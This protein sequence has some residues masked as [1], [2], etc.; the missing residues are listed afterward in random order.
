MKSAHTLI[1]KYFERQKKLIKG[2]SLRSLAYDIGVSPG[3]LSK[4]M[5]GKKTLTASIAHRL[6]KHLRVDNLQS[7]E[8]MNSLQNDLLEVNF[9]N[10]HKIRSQIRP[11]VQQMSEIVIMAPQ[12]EW[13]LGQWYR[14]ALLDFVTCSNFKLDIK[15]LAD[16][17]QLN[18]NIMLDTIKQLK[19]YGFLKVDDAGNLV[20]TYKK[21]RFPAEYSKASIRKYH[22]VQMKRAIQHMNVGQQ[23][24]S[25][26]KRLIVGIS[27]ASNPENIEKAKQ[28]LH[29][30]MY[31]AAEVLS[32]GSCTD[33]YHIS[34][35]LFPQTR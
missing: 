14:L 11:P 15:W 4:I 1:Y 8:I 12:A 20:K 9:G 23:Q 17:F 33:I 22:E 25:Y 19:S 31:E 24:D 18:P 10:V 28:I 32:S 3:Y 16:K 27:V 26:N 29:R 34:I 30:A 35:Q 5:N 6:C 7:N 21:L 13:L 2:L